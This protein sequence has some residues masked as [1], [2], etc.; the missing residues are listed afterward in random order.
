MLFFFLSNKKTFPIS[1]L[2]GKG[3]IYNMQVNQVLFIEKYV[4]SWENIDW[5]FTTTP[6]T[7]TRIQ[8]YF[9]R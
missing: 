2:A 8:R 5:Y 6:L 1:I 9:A 4:L 7:L 3:L